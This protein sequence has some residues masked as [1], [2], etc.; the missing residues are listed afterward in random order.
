MDDLL[1]MSPTKIRSPT[2]GA[3]LAGTLVTCWFAVLP[4]IRRTRPEA[5]RQV[6]EYPAGVVLAVAAS[7]KTALGAPGVA[8]VSGWLPENDWMG[9]SRLP[10]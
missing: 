1:A 9:P 4:N 10:S 2:D 7:R 5:W 6:K 8:D 3:M